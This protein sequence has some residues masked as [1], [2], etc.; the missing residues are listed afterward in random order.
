MVKKQ[1]SKFN[2]PNEAWILHREDIETERDGN[3][4]IYV[5]IDAYSQF[6]FGQEISVELPSV[7][8]I[9]DLIKKAH[10]T[11]G[12]WPEQI[13]IS[14]K[15]PFIEIFSGVC[16]ELDLRLTEMTA[17]ELRP[18]VQSFSD[19]FKNL[20]KGLPLSSPQA[21]M[22]D[23]EREELETF[24]PE[25]YSPCRCAS[26]KKFKFCCQ[27]AFREITFA[28]CD[29]QDGKLN[30]ALKFM[31]QAEER[32]GRTAEVVCRYAIV[33]SFFDERKSHELL[34]EAL[35]LNPKHPRA[36]YVMGIE[37][38]A[39]DE[40]EKAI[41]FYQTAIEN[42]PPD[43]KFHLN[44]TYNN[45]GTAFYSLKKY[46]EAKDVWEKAVVLMPT[47]LMSKKNLYEFIYDNPDLP[48]NLRKI[49]PFIDKYL[50]K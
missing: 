7:V 33:W 18:L 27:K 29:A 48:Q 16:K 17:N 26:G 14:K 38:V 12:V 1:V 32:I 23:L 10:S 11:S 45:M 31:K 47:D 15:D 43:D 8:K 6:L 35:K 30:D 46:Q 20:K 22:T 34:L 5:L 36:N 49:S 19:S 13:L 24:I 28:M 44:E 9:N 50:R 41:R 39:R 3:C 40:Y 25:T 42:Y 37:S 2:K 21:P 4:N